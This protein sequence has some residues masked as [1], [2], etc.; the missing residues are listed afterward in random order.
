VTPATDMLMLVTTLIGWLTVYAV[1]PSNDGDVKYREVP[2]SFQ[3]VKI[4]SKD[5][6]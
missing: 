5:A 1:P 2:S 6:L 4:A 3:E